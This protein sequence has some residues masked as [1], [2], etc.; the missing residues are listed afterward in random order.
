MDAWIRT[1]QLIFVMP[2]KTTGAAYAE[3]N[4]GLFLPII[5]GTDTILH[6]AL[7]RI[8]LENGWEDSEFI[9]NWVASRWEIDSGFGRGTRNTPWQWR[10]TWG[11][12]GASF[13]QYKAWLFDQEDAAVGECGTDHRH[14]GR[15]HSSRRRDDCQAD[16]WPAPEDIV[17]SGEGQLLEQQLPE[18][19]ILRIACDPVWSRK[20]GRPSRLAVRRP[21]TGMVRCGQLPA[22]VLSRKRTGAT[23]EGDRPR[24][25]GRS[26]QAALGLGHWHDLVSGDGGEPG[27][28]GNVQKTNERQSASDSICR[29]SPCGRGTQETR[30]RRRD[31]RRASGHLLAHPDRSPVCRPGTAG[32]GLGRERLHSM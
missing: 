22:D 26:G 24:S 8:I 11:K 10:T 19:G 9:K 4:G 5:P 6:L 31:G 23:K 1:R 28:G 3:K 30:R 17:C 14:R 13:E 16:K 18:H 25:L 15:R 32:S 7:A 2:R 12:L 27:V 20:S 29:T 21:P